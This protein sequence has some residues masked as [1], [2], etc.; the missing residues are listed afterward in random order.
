MNIAV[1]TR[2]LIDGKLDGIGWFTYNTLKIITQ[3]HPEHHFYFIFDRKYDEQFI[4]SENI[5]PIIVPPPT[6]HVVL[7]Q[8]WLK[9]SIPKILKKYNID[10]FLSLDGGIPLKAK[11]PCL[12][13]IHDINFA[14]NPKDLPFSAAKF[15]NTFFPKYAHKAKRIATVSEYSKRDIV[16][17]YKV[18]P[19]KVDVVYNGANQEYRPVSGDVKE[20]IRKKY[21]DG[22]DYF[23]FIGSIHPRKNLKRLVI[24]YDM[25]KKNTD[26]DIKLVVVGAQFFKNSDLFKTREELKF[27]HDIIFT[28]RLESDELKKVLASALALAFVP[29]FEGFGIPILEAMYCDVPVI[30]SNV[31]S[32]PEVAEDAALYVNPMNIENIAEALERMSNDKDLRKEL[33]EK[34]KIQRQKFTWEKTAEKLWNS[35]EKVMYKK[36]HLLDF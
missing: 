22:K 18:S 23:I 11:I 32:M 24:A 8:I 33:I 2:L 13:V 28:G 9:Y 20:E 31:T 21:T 26:S 17:T 25:F 27:K 14:H 35:I 6:R 15:Y 34:G 10:F 16:N 29:Y 4:F 3:N 30:S 7:W 12:T 36:Q 1:N 5:T 19:Q